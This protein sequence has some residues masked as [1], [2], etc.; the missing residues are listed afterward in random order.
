M[1]Q[2]R[3]KW[4]ANWLSDH[5]FFDKEAILKFHQNENIESPEVALKMKRSNI[6]TISTTNILKKQNT[7]SMLY[8]DYVKNL[9]KE[10]Y[11]LF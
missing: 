5:K 8:I 9:E 10:V 4:F 7:T 11:Q 1:K 6:E 3:R 2:S